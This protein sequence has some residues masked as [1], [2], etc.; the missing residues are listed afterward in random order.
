MNSFMKRKIWL[1]AVSA[2][3][4]MGVFGNTAF[5]VSAQK[6]IQTQGVQEDTTESE[7]SS[8]TQTEAVPHSGTQPETEPASEEA[9]PD[10]L[11]DGTD[12][13]EYAGSYHEPG[14]HKQ[15]AYTY[16]YKSSGKLQKGWKKIDGK[17]YYF[18]KKS[19]PDGP[20]GS[21]A[22][23]FCSIDGKQFY[24]S[25]KG[26]LQHGGWRT[27]KGK[28]YYLT[29]RGNAGTLGAMYVGLKKIGDDIFCFNEDGSACVGWTTYK[30]KRYFFSNG[31]KLGL[32]GRAIKGWRKIGDDTYYFASNGVM[33][34]NRWIDGRYVDKK[35]RLLRNGVSPAG[36]K[37]D[38]DGRKIGLAKG[39]FTRSGK[40]YYYVS[41]KK[42]IGFKK[43]GG[44]KYYFNKNGVRKEDGWITVD[45]SRYYL[46][47]CIVQ[48]GWQTI[49]GKRY[50]FKNSGKMSVSTTV[51]GITIGADGAA[52]MSTAPSPE[53]KS[54]L[55]IA[56]HG[57]GDVGA[58]GYYSNS[59]YYE[60]QLTREFAT[61]I[62]QRLKAVNPGLNVV[63]YDQNYDCYQVLAGRKSGPDPQFKKYDYVLEVHFNATVA[64]SK[65]PK[66]DGSYKGIG[67][68]V[69]SAKK[70]TSIDRNIV[71]TV[72]SRTGFRVWGGGTGIFA[73]SGLLNAKTAQNAG[74]SYGLLE[75][76]FIDDRDDITFYN[77]NK[78]AMAQAV[79][80]ALNSSLTK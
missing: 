22:T 54:V 79:A 42:T 47:D 24:F 44:K 77:K 25:R 52:D 62:M 12:Q 72:A 63:M 36:Y 6:T 4:I 51:D 74:V 18:R 67:M 13:E 30:G 58:A 80:E 27:I 55:I 1:A 15:G 10:A 34:K 49:D 2:A 37:T 38:E 21:M 75:S 53:Q 31:K 33:Q 32:R 56:G 41:G 26:V 50:H 3:M 64:S 61:L 40:T 57:Q 8:E 11:P 23:G 73:S 78:N 14:W 20:K 48:T 70:D 28:N 45:G 5:S 17:M 19:D 9:T 68:Y 29:P 69:N 39:W 59:T 7:Y 60:Y 35:G 76:A 43:I 66:G 65:D 16:Y 71:A 46:S